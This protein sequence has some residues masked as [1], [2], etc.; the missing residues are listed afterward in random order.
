M[1]EVDRLVKMANQIAENFSFHDNAAA[2]TAEHL[3]RFW[4]PS[5]RQKIVAHDAA[6]GGG[7]TATAKTAVQRIA[8]S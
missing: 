2:L 4:A 6:G 3:Q 1:Q 5:M 8:G 7:L